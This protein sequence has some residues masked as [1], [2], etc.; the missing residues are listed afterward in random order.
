M[1]KLVSTATGLLLVGVSIFLVSCKSDDYY[2]E[3]AVIS[4]R[5]YVLKNA[6]DLD[7]IQQEYIR[8]NKPVIMAENIL[9]TYSGAKTSVICG[10][11]SQVCIAWV[12]PGE[13]EAFVV[14]GTSDNRL[15]NWSPYRLIRKTYQTKEY[16][17]ITAYDSAARYVMNN[18]LYLST[19]QRNRVRF[20]VPQAVKTKFP[21][22]FDPMGTLKPETV[23]KLK[24]FPLQTSFVWESLA[25]GRKIVV[26]GVGSAE[27]ADWTPVFGQEMDESDLNQNSVQ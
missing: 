16:N 14:F 19:E 27:F 3:Q 7:V 20:D 15:F 1:K 5:K 26:C 25:K 2:R 4:A 17:R 22:D 10:V 8:F 12:V 18:M 23:T 21:L 24:A 13:K 6:K 9:G 11:T